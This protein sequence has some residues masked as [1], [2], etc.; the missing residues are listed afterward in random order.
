MVR[1][2]TAKY[3]VEHPCSSAACSPAPPPR[4]GHLPAYGLLGEAFQLR[5]DLLG[6]FGDPERT[7]KAGLDDLRAHRPT[8]LL[9]ETWQAA[10][11]SQRERLRQVLGRSDLDEN[12]PARGARPQWWSWRH[13]SGSSG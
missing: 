11:T 7:G 9:A 10:D 5:D 13:R 12:H 1:Y 3:T 8:A 4:C 6:L 2:K